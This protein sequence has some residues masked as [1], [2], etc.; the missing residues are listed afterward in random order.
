MGKI[1]L[2]VIGDTHH[3]QEA[4]LHGPFKKAYKK[5]TAE[6]FKRKVQG[7]VH[8]GDL[9]LFS[10][11]STASQSLDMRCLTRP[12]AKAGLFEF[13]IDG[14]HDIDGANIGE[15]TV[16]SRL[17]D[18]VDNDTWKKMYYMNDYKLRKVEVNG[19]MLQV[20]PLSYPPRNAFAKDGVDGCDTLVALASKFIQQK[21]AEGVAESD[22][23]I[24]LLIIYHG[25]IVA[26]NLKLGNETN[27]IC[28]YD[29]QI[30]IEMFPERENC[31]VVAGHIHGFQVLRERAPFV[32]YAGSFVHHTIDQEGKPCG[33]LFVS[34]NGQGWDG[35]FFPIEEIK[36]R[37][38]VV[39]LKKEEYKNIAPEVAVMREIAAAQVSSD[40]KVKIELLEEYP[41]Q[42]ISET[43]VREALLQ[44]GVDV[45]S[46]SKKRENEVTMDVARENVVKEMGSTMHDHILVFAENTPEVK[47]LIEQYGI[48]K[49]D[50]RSAH[51]DISRQVESV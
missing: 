45:L 48:T 51:D 34:F 19:V 13:R 16:N 49:D 8:T 14:N 27:M 20:L 36:L 25:T 43:K 50:L 17:G 31:A 21:L 38:V 15:P 33:A 1:D 40:S 42:V 37:R 29:V 28:G 32:A 30:P 12:I 6:V 35:E 22:P 41:G 10:N 11:I 23:N 4:Y 2:A 7:L 44:N 18:I 5:L 39:D 26:N 9:G 46:V 3:K 47:A 24:P